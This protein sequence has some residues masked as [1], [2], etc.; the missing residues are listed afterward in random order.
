MFF[1]QDMTFQYFFF[2]TYV[3]YFFQVLPI[4]LLAGF[5]AWLFRFRKGKGVPMAQKVFS[6]LF[7]CYLTGLICLVAG[8][9]FVQ[10]FWYTLLYRAPS[11]IEISFFS[12]G[13]SLVPSFADSFT[14]EQIGNFLMFLPFGPLYLLSWPQTTGKKTILVGFGIVLLIEVLQPIF[15]RMFD[16]ND[17]ILN[18]VSMVV[19]TAAFLGIKRAVRR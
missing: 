19:S 7:V 4:S 16:S 13:F 6:C 11:G 14:Q 8:L 5:L 15:G 1:P 3:G 9:R 10:V 2:D 18:T 17:V 12:G